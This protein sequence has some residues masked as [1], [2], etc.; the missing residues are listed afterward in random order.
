ML[1][2]LN[3]QKVEKMSDITDVEQQELSHTITLVSY[4]VT[5]NARTWV[6][7]ELAC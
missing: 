3:H 5:K 7:K 1:N 6:Q 2:M 4:L